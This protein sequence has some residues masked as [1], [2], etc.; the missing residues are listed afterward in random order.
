MLELLLKCILLHLVADY[1]LQGWLANGKQKNW[2]NDQIEKMVD[3]YKEQLGVTNDPE[4]KVH[5]IENERTRLKHKYGCDWSMAMFEHSLYWT[6]VTFAPLIFF[7]NISE[8]TMLGIVVA[9]T[10]IHYIIDDLKANKFAINLFDDQMFHFAQILATVT[11]VD[12]WFM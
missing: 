9:N 4:D 1:T 6:L 3:A 8:W 10:A 2:W 12:F 5:H 7:S 11:V